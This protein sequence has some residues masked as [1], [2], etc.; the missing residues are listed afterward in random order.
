MSRYH[1]PPG[2]PNHICQC[3]RCMPNAFPS[4]AQAE[5][6]Q[7]EGHISVRFPG[8][9]HRS[10]D[11]YIDGVKS[12]WTIECMAGKDGW[13]IV[14]DGEDPHMCFNCGGHLCLRLVRGHIRLEVFATE[15]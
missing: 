12:A 8:K 4:E 7:R 14:A 2:D 1:I 11:I 15:S 3:P 5:V 10:V 6:P 13:A 9:Q